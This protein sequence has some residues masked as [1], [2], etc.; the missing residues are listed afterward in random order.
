M[1]FQCKWRAY[2]SETSSPDF[3][4]SNYVLRISSSCWQQTR[5]V[6]VFIA[7]SAPVIQL[8]YGI[9]I[10]RHFV[11]CK[12]TLQKNFKKWPEWNARIF[13]YITTTEPDLLE[14]NLIQS[15]TVSH[16]FALSCRTFLR[17][18]DSLMITATSWL[19]LT[20]MLRNFV[21]FACARPALHSFQA[22]PLVWTKGQRALLNDTIKLAFGVMA[23]NPAA[24]EELFWNI[25]E[26]LWAWRTWI[27]WINLDFMN[28]FLRHES[29]GRHLSR[30]EADA[31]TK[32][33]DRVME[34]ITQWLR[35]NAIESFEFSAA[36]NR[37]TVRSTGPVYISRCPW[38]FMPL[39]DPWRPS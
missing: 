13:K 14:Y 10:W 37:I 38:R 36:T 33:S 15:R 34:D 32:P 20:C 6:P 11:G 27:F 21:C 26:P 16:G 1:L 19:A 25:A 29:Y 28:V 35:G 39:C 8:L 30:E 23:E 3:R 17:V 7:Y 12:F 22:D 24:L 2:M 31:L 5:N 9:I 18:R 4:Q